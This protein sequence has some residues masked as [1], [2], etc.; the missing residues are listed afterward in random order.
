[1][2]PGARTDALRFLEAFWAGI[3]GSDDVDDKVI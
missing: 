1:M 2:A 3:L